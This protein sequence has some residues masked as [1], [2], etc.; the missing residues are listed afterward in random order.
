MCRY[1]LVI[2]RCRVNDV[3]NRIFSIVRRV[4]VEYPRVCVEYQRVSG[5]CVEYQE[6]VCVE[7]PAYILP[8][9]SKLANTHASIY[10]MYACVYTCMLCMHVCMHVY[11][12]I[13]VRIYI[14]LKHL[15]SPLRS[16]TP[17][18]RSIACISF[19]T[20]ACVS[21]IAVCS[22]SAHVSI[23]QHTSAYVRYVRILLNTQ[24]ASR[25]S[26]SAQRHH[27]SAYIRYV[28]ICQHTSAYVR[29][30]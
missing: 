23:R 26:L 11:V 16:P 14:Y 27:T 5:G 20:A 12:Y 25:P 21:P 1:A 24:R 7:Y 28:R 10:A 8:A 29:K 9:P 13:Y 22:V 19:S 6:G 3:S 30:H 18:H 17:L 15:A 4:C 2:E